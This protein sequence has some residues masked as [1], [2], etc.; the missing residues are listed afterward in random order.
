MSLRIFGCF[1]AGKVESAV[2]QTTEAGH[3]GLP[4]GAPLSVSHWATRG[5]RRARAVSHVSLERPVQSF[6][7][8]KFKVPPDLISLLSTLL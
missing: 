3:E 7:C 5:Q 1:G 6:V 4:K 2:V 8:L